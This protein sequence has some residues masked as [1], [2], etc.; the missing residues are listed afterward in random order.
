MQ[1]SSA[2]LGAA[3]ARGVPAGTLVEAGQ[4]RAQVGRVAR[5][6]GHLCQPPRDF[7]QRLRP[8]GCTG[9]RLQL[10]MPVG[11]Q[12]GRWAEPPPAAPDHRE[13]WLRG[14]CLPCRTS[15]LSAP[16]PG[17]GRARRAPRGGVRHHGEVVALVTP[18]LGQCDARVD[19]GLPRRHGH[20]A[21]VGHLR[22]AEA[23]RAAQGQ[24]ACMP[25]ERHAVCT[26][27]SLH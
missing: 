15:C 22:W 18:V 3:Q 24:T 9:L 10:V 14:T 20:V 27:G 5:V 7:A 17:C 21:G 25:R 19:G 8:P 23:V 12:T 26:R 6:G 16:C 1:T 11:G 2:A 13:P 4:T